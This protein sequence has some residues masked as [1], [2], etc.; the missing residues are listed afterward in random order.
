MALCQGKAL[1]A[2]FFALSVLRKLCNHPDL[3]LNGYDG[4]AEVGAEGDVGLPSAQG[5]PIP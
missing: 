3:L 5:S 2:V 1:G 4:E